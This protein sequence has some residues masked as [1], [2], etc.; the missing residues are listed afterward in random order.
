MGDTALVPWLIERMADRAQARVAGEAFSTITGADL[1]ALDLDQPPADHVSGPS[2]DP[3][4]DDVALDDDEN[5]PWP[6]AARVQRWWQAQ[7]AGMPA[8]QRC[9]LGAP[10][11]AQRLH[12]VLRTG[13][14]RQRAMAAHHLVL[15][16][17]G[18]ALF[19]VAAPA[20]RQRRLLDAAPATGLGTAAGDAH[21]TRMTF[22]H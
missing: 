21:R 20:W 12:E 17:P 18:H 15:L 16:Q 11:Q 19:P 9:F 14:Q 8:G 5:L 3:A 4:D 22:G 7:A 6:D 2:D 13:T 1:A 10:V